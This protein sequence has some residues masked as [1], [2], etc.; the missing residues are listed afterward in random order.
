VNLRKIRRSK[1]KANGEPLRE[2][3]ARGTTGKVKGPARSPT[4]VEQR[5]QAAGEKTIAA[6][7]EAVEAERAASFALVEKGAVNTQ[8]EGEVA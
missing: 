3:P 2:G 4:L 7:R 8:Q 6:L 5:R 1:Q